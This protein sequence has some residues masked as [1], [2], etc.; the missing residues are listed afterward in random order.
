MLP[1]NASTRA[2]ITADVCFKT[3]RCVWMSSWSFSRDTIPYEAL[4]VY[5]P[6]EPQTHVMVKI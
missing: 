2:A 3:T 1:Q 5:S 4:I 6:D